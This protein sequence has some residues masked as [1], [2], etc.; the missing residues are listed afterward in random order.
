VLNAPR[1]PVGDFILPAS[2]FLGYG[3]LP[4]PAAGQRANLHLKFNAAR[5][6]RRLRGI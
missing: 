2:R 3:S 5:E 1:S 6:R 4:A